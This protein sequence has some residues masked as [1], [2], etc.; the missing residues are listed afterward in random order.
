MCTEDHITAFCISSDAVSCFNRLWVGV[1]D[2]LSD[3]YIP[4]NVVVS[5]GMTVA[6]LKDKVLKFQQEIHQTAHLNFSRINSISVVLSLTDCRA[7]YP[8]SAESLVFQ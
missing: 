4:I 3:D 2:A 1:E 6:Q 7:S 8:A 5:P